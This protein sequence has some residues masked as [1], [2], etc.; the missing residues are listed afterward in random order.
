MFFPLAEMQGTSMNERV[1]SNV[2]RYKWTHGIAERLEDEWDGEV[3][4]R[5]QR[6]S[7]TFRKLL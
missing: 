3:I 5:G 7:I 4:P 1:G 6:V 2:R